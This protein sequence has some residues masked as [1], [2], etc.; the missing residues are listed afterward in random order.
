ME[1]QTNDKERNYQNMINIQIPRNWKVL[2]P[3]ELS[4]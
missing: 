2:Q 3:Y 1:A 4:Y